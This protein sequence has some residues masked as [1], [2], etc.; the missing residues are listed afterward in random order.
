MKMKFEA[1]RSS[2]VHIRELS[3]PRMRFRFMKGIR[4]ALFDI[5][6]DAAREAEMMI[7][8]EGREGKAYDING[9]IHI[10]SSPGDA[11]ANLSG[12]LK[13]SI[14]FAVRGYHEVEYG[15]PVPYAKFLEVGTNR[16]EARP[17]LGKVE[18]MRGEMHGVMLEQGVD[19]E[20][21]RRR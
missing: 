5:G 1:A 10:A 18:E 4:K 14:S 8:N 12:R 21:K 6:L 3:S 9:F 7:N 17:F 20:I 11:P 19:D 15:S 2:E 16:M 13:R